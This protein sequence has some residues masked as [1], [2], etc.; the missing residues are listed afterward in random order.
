MA[1][2]GFMEKERKP[3]IFYSLAGTLLGTGYFPL[4][5]ATVASFIVCVIIWFLLTSSLLSYFITLL[6]VFVLSILISSK[7]ETFWET[8][9]RKIVIDEV[10]GMLITLFAIPQKFLFFLIGFLLFRFFDIVKPYPIN[11]SQKLNKGWG[12]V[13]DD[14]IA[15]IYSS[16]ILWI[17]IFLYHLI[18]KI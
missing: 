6:I 2:T 14:V 10:V 5:P 15:G 11:Q 4:A 18:K 1:K 17:F 7:L 9:D 13:I 12:I 8:D 3:P 16:I